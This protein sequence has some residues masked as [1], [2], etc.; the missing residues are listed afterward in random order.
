MPVSAQQE[1]G[2]TTQLRLQKL[3]VTKIH[4]FL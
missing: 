3:L 4:R 1:K 2:K